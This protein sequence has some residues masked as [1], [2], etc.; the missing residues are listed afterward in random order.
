MS[1]SSSVD[2]RLYNLPS[3][4][5]I[6]VI[7]I[8]I[9]HGWNPS[10]KGEVNY[11]PVGDGGNFSWTSVNLNREE[12]IKLLEE[13]RHRQEIIGIELTWQDQYVGGEF[14]FIDDEN[15]SAS[16]SIN[17]KLVRNS[18]DTDVNWYLQRILAPLR[19]HGIGIES[20]VYSEHV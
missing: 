13:K 8:L 10:P 3:D 12:M 6:E 19:S 16:L 11:L 20:Y 17:R 7:R 14:L 15:F 2:F 4:G 1:V 18:E 9:G 5:A